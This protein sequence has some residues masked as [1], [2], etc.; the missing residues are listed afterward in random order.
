MS[1]GSSDRL[2]SDWLNGA[3]D[4]HRAGRCAPALVGY[5]R[6]LALAPDHPDALHLSGLALHHIGRSDAGLIRLNRAIRA[7]PVFPTAFNS[8]GSVLADLGRNEDAR[9]ACL[10]A[11]AQ[12]GDYA[13]AHTNLGTVLHAMGDW[14]AAESAYRQALALA[15]QSLNAAL[16]LGLLLRD[17]GRVALAAQHFYDL[18]SAHPD[19]SAAWRGLALSLCALDHADAESCLLR[20]LRDTPTDAE[21]LARLAERWIAQGRC[22]EVV[23]VLEPARSAHPNHALLHFL[24]ALALQ[25]LNRLVEAVPLYR[26]AVACDPGLNGAWNNLGVA[27]LDLGRDREAFPVLRVALIWQPGDAMILNNIGTVL[28]G[29]ERFDTAA[30]L[31]RRAL[32]LRPDYS[33]VLNNL[34]SL[35]TAW[36]Q[37]DRAE[38]LRR[39]AIAA[40]PDHAEAWMN[41]ASAYEE[42]DE[43][44]TAEGLFR[45]AV[46]LVPTNPLALTGYGLVLQVQGKWDLAEAAHRAALAQDANNAK[47]LANLGMLLWQKAENAAQAEAHLTRALDRDPALAPARL[48][49]GII[50]LTDGR[51]TEGWADYQWR[52]RAKGYVDR[53]IAAIRWN[54]ED[55]SGKRLLVWPEQGVGDEILFSACWPDLIRRVGHAVF[56]CDPRLVPLFQ[57]SFPTATVRPLS[58]DANGDERIVPPGVDAHIPAGDVPRLLRGTLASFQSARPWLV[59]EPER[60]GEWRRRVRALGDGLAVGVAWRSQKMTTDRLAAYTRLD[61]WG[62]IFAVPGLVFVNVQYGDC[63]AELTAAEERFGVRIHRWD[64]LDLKNDFDG[65]AALLANLDLVVSPAMSVGELAGAVGT[66]VWRFCRRDWTQLGTAVRPWFPSMRV[67]QPHPDEG[68]NDVLDHM[69]T[70]LRAL[71]RPRVVPVVTVPAAVEDD[72]AAAIALYRQG[73]VAAATDRVQRVLQ[74]APDHEVAQHLAGVL[75]MRR[76]DPT[77]GRAHFAAAAR[78]NPLN[79]PAHAGHADALQRL[80]RCEE[81]LVSLRAAMTLDPAG[82]DS[83]VNLTALLR[84]LD[85]PDAARRMAERAVRLRPD[86]RLA[87]AHLAALSDTAAQA[88]ALHRNAVVLAPDQAEA[89]NNLAG[90]L[91]GADRFGDSARLFGWALRLLPGLVAAWTGRG[92]SLGALGR[93]DEAL[94]CHRTAIALQPD[95]PEAFGNTAFLFQRMNRRAPALSQYRRAIAVDPRHGQARYNRGLLLLEAGEMRPGWAEHEWRFATPQ[96]AGQR[97]R[98]SAKAWRGENIARSR[99]LVWREQGIGD[100]ILFSSCYPDLL[101]RAGRLVIECDRRLVSLF[102]RSF[103]GAVVRVDSGDPRDVDVQ[104]AAGGVPR[105]LRSEIRRFPTNASWLVP[106]PARVEA[107]R[108]RVDALGPGLLVGIGWRSQILNAQRQGAYT[109]LEQWGPIFA[110]P[111]VTF[112][113]VQYG[114]CEAEIRAAEQRFGVTIHRWADLDL[115]DDFEGVAAL[116]TNLDLVL[117]PA[118]SAGELAG[119]LGVPVWRFCGADWTELGCAVRPWFP[120]QRLFHPGADGAL[121]GALARIAAELLRLR[122]GGDAGGATPA[123]TPDDDLERAVDAHRAGDFDRA[124]TLY[125]RVLG[126]DPDQPVALHLSGLLL[127]Q[128]GRADL[129]ESRVAAAV[130]AWPD[131]AAALVSLG[132][133]RQALDRPVS[134]AACFRAALALR[135]EDGA[136]W[137]NLGNAWAALNALSVAERAHHHAVTIAPDLPDLH[138]NH[139]V[140]LSRMDRVAAAVDAHRQALRL[141]PDRASSWAGR[142]V[143]ERRLGRLDAADRAGRVALALDPSDAD[144]LANRGRLLRELGRAAA[145]LRVCDRAL[146]LD[147]QSAAA[148]FNGGVIRLA[149]G[150]LPEGWAGY[151]HRF[152]SNA[153]QG[154]VRRP[155]VPEWRGEPLTNRRLLVWREQGIGDELM[156]ATSLP[157]VIAQAGHVTVEC[158]PRFVPLFARSFPTI[159]VR[160]QPV[161]PGEPVSD[162]DVHA[163]IGSLPRWLR[164]E[165]CRFLSVESPLLRAD[166][167]AVAAWRRRLAA[168]GG[169]LMIGLAWRSGQLDPERLPDYTRLEDWGP[170]FAV[171]GVIIINLQYGECAPDL[172]RARSLIGRAPHSFADLDVKNDLD[173]LAA[174]M[175]ALDL[176]ITPAISTGELAAALGVPV[177]RIGRSGDWTALGTSVRPW[178][179]SMRV[180]HPAD[181]GVVADV[182]P[183]VA[184]ALQRLRPEG[185]G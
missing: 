162:V 160:P 116:M 58:I 12:H 106:D 21:L 82:A 44:A 77:A 1:G 88:L 154:A 94:R 161:Q 64:D 5:D 115:K 105:L 59:P 22:A 141:A 157:D 102:T 72:V 41:L 144:A 139:A 138:D 99:L 23:E 79:G 129:G 135:P 178:F 177:W 143:A 92:N 140:V 153:T 84:R 8:L 122:G 169:G 91:H 48:N 117:S 90:A 142:S 108:R 164:P 63:E 151:D 10:Q 62:G 167:A 158:D 147:P 54:G 98:L 32:R 61:D 101:K 148:A 136:A 45:R 171:P 96:F 47:A 49:R 60:L 134:A 42:R 114:P 43:L 123:P 112:V 124:A 118:M 11:I 121:S 130:A 168:L 31:Y 36:K 133:L 87:H 69:A 111:G 103:P 95:F 38:A 100:E 76:N 30:A 73:D 20:A 75:A 26:Q 33:K 7:Q 28:E 173:G 165:L 55:L 119:A 6:V 65:V 113:N 46:T 149:Q 180:F 57:R 185:A 146:R 24:L 34:G 127:H 175:S 71:S 81:A 97:R 4:H 3:L 107:W 2:R 86:L 163:P 172:E 166:K 83:L 152:R 15:P 110:V 126:Q 13:E 67:F 159:T 89:L 19:F 176:V 85:R 174:L 125:E 179:P 39:K 17:S 50:R 35:C 120:S 56:E 18:I 182:I 40:Q 145:A 132:T 52:L 104:I 93:V 27:L 137:S 70:A 80:D 68:L 9:R 66:P 14:A 37:H 53:R 155:G 184:D 131:Y 156:F 78:R 170:L 51:L 25:G 74:A 128:R 16:N 150:Q 29:A 183:A 109:S 181:G